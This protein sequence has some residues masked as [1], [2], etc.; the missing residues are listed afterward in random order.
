V[1]VEIYV[2]DSIDESS[3]S[4]AVSFGDARISDEIWENWFNSWLE[5]LHPNLPPA[6]SYEIGL[7]FTDDTEIQALNAQYRQ[8]NKP[9]DVLSFAAL[10]IDFPQ[11]EEMLASTPLYLGDILIQLACKLSSR[12]IV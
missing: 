3:P 11:N 9:T 6:P 4:E 2:Q 1:R 5:I 10:E 8:Q 7:R 12:N